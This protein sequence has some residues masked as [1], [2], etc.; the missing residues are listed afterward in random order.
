[1]EPSDGKDYQAPK[2]QQHRQ[3]FEWIETY[4]SYQVV[5]DWIVLKENEQPSAEMFF[6]AYLAKNTP[7]DRPV[8]F[9]FNG[10][11]GSS[12]VFCHLG[13]MGPKRIRFNDDGTLPNSPVQLTD[14]TES[15]LR[16]TD[17]VFIDPIGTGF[18]RTITRPKPSEQKN[19]ED[20]KEKNPYFAVQKDLDSLGEFIQRF[21]SRFSLWQKPLFICGESY[22]GYRV[23]RLAK[24]MHEKYHLGVSGAILVSPALEFRDLMPTDYSIGYWIN[25][26]PT[27]AAIAHHHGVGRNQNPDHSLDQVL[28]NAEQLAVTGYAELLAAGELM[29]ETKRARLL[30]KVAA[31]IGFPDH[32]LQLAQGRIAFPEFSHRLLKDKRQ[33]VGWYDGSV[34]GFDIFPNREQQE[35][36]DPTLFPGM[37]AYASSINAWLRHELKVDTD[38]EYVLLNLEANKQWLADDKEHDV[39]HQVGSVDD[40]R[41]GL[42]ANP[43]M[44]VFICHGIF[45]QVTPYFASKR[46]IHQM[47]LDNKHKSRVDWKTYP[48]GHMFY[49]WTESRLRLT[50]DIRHFY[51]TA[52]SR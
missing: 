9:V 52:L 30:K 23:A 12:S 42:S 11:P 24:L 17:L 41:F 2:G 5:A 28:E 13:A 16:F 31:M 35:S 38:R 32:D 25:L 3:R 20:K 22:G 19:N 7:A 46:L 1:M 34:T 40:L 44:R 48:G 36:P 37:H 6:T 29:P 26:L 8:T 21:L 49:S 45:D 33:L 27:L 51:Q 10:G 18:S 14:N 43:H 4:A 50:Q 15:W 39:F 47:K